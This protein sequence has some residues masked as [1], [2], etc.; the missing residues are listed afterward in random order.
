MLNIQ[1]VIEDAGPRLKLVVGRAPDAGFEARI[2][3]RLRQV[4]PSLET[5]PLEYVQDLATNV[6]GKR[7]WFVDRRT[8]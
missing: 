3:A 7:R 1:M 8:H 4:H 5:A 2:R 6:A